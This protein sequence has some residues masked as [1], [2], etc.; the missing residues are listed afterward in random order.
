MSLTEK[1]PNCISY[2]IQVYAF[3]CTSNSRR[4]DDIP[5][6]FP[7]VKNL[8]T[9]LWVA[10]G[11]PEQILSLGGAGVL[12]LATHVGYGAE[13]ALA[14]QEGLEGVRVRVDDQ[15]DDDHVVA[16]GDEWVGA[17][18]EPLALARESG[19]AVVHIPG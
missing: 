12:G 1:I 17:A 15:A 6:W 16:G 3:A 11:V 10:R 13:G 8:T 18:D 14:V 9:R 2:L 19:G 4:P 5:R 7:Q